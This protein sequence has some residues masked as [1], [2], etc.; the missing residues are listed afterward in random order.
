MG[1][2]STYEN[3][4]SHAMKPP[5]SRRT[6]SKLLIY[7]LS[8]DQKTAASTTVSCKRSISSRENFYSNGGLPSMLISPR[9]LI[10]VS[11]VRS[12]RGTFSISTASRRTAGG[13]S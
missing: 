12:R 1:S 2:L 11:R 7:A 4:T 8:V 9:S 10:P 6:R 3:S 5:S 13:I